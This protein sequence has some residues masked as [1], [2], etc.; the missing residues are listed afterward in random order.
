MPNEQKP[1]VPPRLGV[2]VEDLRTTYGRNIEEPGTINIH[3]NLNHKNVP[4]ERVSAPA[5]V[6]DVD[7]IGEISAFDI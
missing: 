6:R 4:I 3:Q 2:G 5:Q 1:S 7:E